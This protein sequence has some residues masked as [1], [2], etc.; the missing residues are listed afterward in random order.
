[1]ATAV[2]AR[3]AELFETARSDAEPIGPAVVEATDALAAFVLGGGKRVRPLFAHAG[4]EVAHATSGA[5]DH[6]ADDTDEAMIDLGAALELVQACALVH[7]DIIDASATRRG[8]PTVH[9]VFADR[10]R[11]GRWLGDAGRFGESMAILIGDLALAWADDLAAPLPAR[12]APVW[13]TMRTEVLSGQL[14]D[15]ANEASRD[16]SL[17]AAERVIAYK[18]A[19]YT[20]ARP[21]Q[22]GA[23]LGGAGD[24]LVGELR[25]IGLNLGLAF[26]L[27]DDLLGVY[28]DPA[29][30]GKP[31]G[32]DLITGK[33]TVLVAEGFA[34]VTD[35]Q[36][37]A[38]RASLGTDLDD[39]SLARARAIL[40][41]SGAQ[42]AVENR[43]DSALSH[44]LAGIE[45]LPTSPQA[46]ESLADLAHRI[47]HRAA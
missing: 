42:A 38:L 16:E 11:E 36:A 27:R 46:R 13:S 9:R 24:D 3:L 21:L 2:E 29:V 23:V 47:T 4:R 40:T 44:A 5:G 32:D 17:A 34:R 30:T 35:E 22:L 1:M 10:H 8:N 18:T 31:S 25:A 28:G 20:V 26:Q 43:I 37:A 39:A 7:D 12:V 45:S 41:E 19:G 15:I 6:P 33:R 14:L